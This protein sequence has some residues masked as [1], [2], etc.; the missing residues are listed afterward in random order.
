MTCEWQTTIILS[1]FAWSVATSPALSHAWSWKV[2]FFRSDIDDRRLLTDM[3]DAGNLQS[4]KL[5]LLIQQE[6][7]GL[8][9]DELATHLTPFKVQRATVPACKTHL[10][11]LLQVLVLVLVLVKQSGH[12]DGSSRPKIGASKILPNLPKI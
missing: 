3:D 12:M 9:V 5:N 7:K 6:S 4:P 2:P 10:A 11:A 8:S 1:A